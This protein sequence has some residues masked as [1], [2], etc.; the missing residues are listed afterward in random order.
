MRLI[1]IV[2]IKTGAAKFADSAKT[3]GDRD[4]AKV[5]ADNVKDYSNIAIA[6]GYASAKAKEVSLASKNAKDINEKINYLWDDTIEAW[7][8]SLTMQNDKIFSGTE[9]SIATLDALIRDGRSYA[10]DPLPRVQV[11]KQATKFIASIMVPD[12]WRLQ[13]FYPVLLDAGFR[14]GTKGIGID[15]W[16]RQKNIGDA[17]FCFNEG[18]SEYGKPYSG[19]RQYQLWGVKGDYQCACSPA[20]RTCSLGGGEMKCSMLSNLPGLKS[21]K[22]P[23]E[24]WAGANIVDM[25]TK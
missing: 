24:D 9:E 21:I 8:E 11:Q 12:V 23:V 17:E 5:Q 3:K 15:Q 2:V 19:P 16:T 13:G 14:C 4:W 22:K 10:R 20:G 25:V 7:K 1:R 18:G 6:S